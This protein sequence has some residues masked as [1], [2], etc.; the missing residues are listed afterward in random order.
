MRRGGKWRRKIK[1]GGGKS[2]SSSKQGAD[3]VTTDVG[4]FGVR[5]EASDNIPTE[6]GRL[7]GPENE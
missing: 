1:G 7:Q 4:C 3:Q 2:D 6:A 5:G